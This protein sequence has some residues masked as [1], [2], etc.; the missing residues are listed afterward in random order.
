MSQPL[1]CQ[2][3]CLSFQTLEEHQKHI[4]ELHV[5]LMHK[6][7]TCRKVFT[8]AALLEKHK[9][10]HTGVK[11]YVCNLCNKSYQVGRDR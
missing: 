2:K 11:P 6:C 8:S 1:N 9:S 7:Q 5:K 10:V 4:E 3:C